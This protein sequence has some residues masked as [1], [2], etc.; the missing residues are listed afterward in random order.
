MGFN[1]SFNKLF[2][3]Y[4]IYFTEDKNDIGNTHLFNQTFPCMTNSF[5][6][7]DIPVMYSVVSI[8]CI[9]C[10]TLVSVLAVNNVRLRSA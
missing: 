6:M 8:N 3:Y 7:H 4:C 2:L 1:R 10:F 5:V 9:T